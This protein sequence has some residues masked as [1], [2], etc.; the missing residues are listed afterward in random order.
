MSNAKRQ[1]VAVSECP[2]SW[3]GRD[4]LSATQFDAACLEML[5]QLSDS[6]K[7][8]VKRGVVLKL[9]E[10]RVLG[11]VFMEPSTRTA[12]S[13]QS[14]A[15]RLGGSSI[16]INEEGSSAKKG[17]L[18]EDTMRCLEC[19]C[20]ALVLR[21]S[22]VGSAQKAADACA[23]PV[24]NGGDGVGEHPTQALL[25]AYTMRCEI[26]AAEAG[27]PSNS[28]SSAA[29]AAG[30]STAGAATPVP[31]VASLL[32]GKVVVLVGD[33]KHGRTVHSLA[34]LLARTYPGSCSLK[35][36]SPPQLAMPQEVLDVLTANGC[37]FTQH[38]GL[39][40]AVVMSAD[41]LYVTRVQKERFESLAEYEQLKLKYVVDPALLAKA[42][43]TLVLLHPLPR[44]GE[45]DV[46]CD[47][48][49]R[50]AYFRQ[51]EN[52]MYV[53]MAL[54]CLVLGADLTGLLPD[55]KPLSPAV[56]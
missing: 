18:L 4:V 52:G 41:V 35:L 45:I 23:K 8:S 30:T 54:L 5:Y 16:M 44:V 48:D 22:V 34:T 14:A 51:M 9:L 24:L 55:Q 32:K 31:P 46:A 43:A 27:T 37:S 20:D 53:R 33:L 39:D 19:Y 6:L 49:P 56:R 42:K 7:E 2:E 3:I 26:S 28:N 25:D 50:A 17:E 1:K 40:D 36:V 10:G 47:S 15:L 12:C 29:S 38:E 11:N 21:H 13:F